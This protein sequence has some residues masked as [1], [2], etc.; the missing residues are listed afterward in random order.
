MT[1]LGGNNTKKYKAGILTK[2]LRIIAI[3]VF[4]AL[5]I[6]GIAAAGGPFGPPQPIAREA[7]GLH[8][9]I[10]Y[11]HHEDRYK[12]GTEF[13]TRQDQVYSEAGYGA[14]NRWDIYARIGV[15]NLKIQDAFSSSSA[16][17]A[18]SN[19]DFD[20][21]LKFF[22]TLGAKVFYPFSKTFGMGAFVQGSYA[23]NTYKDD[24]SGTS[25]GTPYRAVLTVQDLWDV[26][27]GIG[28]QA[29]IPY[30]IRLYA[31]PYVY[32]S[33]A[34]ASLSTNVPGL[35]FSAADT[36]IKNKTNAGGFTGIDVPLAKG[37]RLNVEGQYSERFSAGGAI[38]YTY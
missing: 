1:G 5:T 32:Y 15:S 22:G 20:E 26:N 4:M 36:T 33:E 14:Q 30:G 3:S 11:W 2:A 35:Q 21:N 8:T 25:G 28:F 34:T 24:V 23:F 27:F 37:F 12:N 7:G 10:G 31:G 16:L 29:T 17:T 38:T 6:H 9:A 18:T 19:N 13:V